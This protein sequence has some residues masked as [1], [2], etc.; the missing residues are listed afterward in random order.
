MK[1]NSNSHKLIIFDY[2]CDSR[3]L[4]TNMAMS[5]MNAQPMVQWTYGHHAYTGSD[6]KTPQSVRNSISYTRP[7]SIE[8]RTYMDLL[9]ANIPTRHAMVQEM[10]NN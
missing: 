9:C 7:V 1:Q 5:C 4:G 2:P 3:V 10:V 6:D 8:A